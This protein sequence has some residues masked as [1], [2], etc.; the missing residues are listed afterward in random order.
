L[1]YFEA[2]QALSWAGV[3][4]DRMNCFNCVDQE[5]IYKVS[6]LVEDVVAWL[7]NFQ[8]DVIITHPYEGGHP[9]HDAAALIASLALDRLAEES[10][11]VPLLI[12][13]SS[14]HAMN[15]QLRT[16]EFLDTSETQLSIKLTAER[17]RRK[18]RM[19]SCYASQAAVLQSF[20]TDRE[21]FRPAPAYDFHVAPHAGKLWFECLGWEMTGQKWRTLAHAALN[22]MNQHVCR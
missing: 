17:R 9:D 14:Y 13:M 6:S 21:V 7:R 20:G 11:G 16:G 15:Q 19:L 5:A 22:E 2:Q 8:P 18:Q 12:E 3:P 4:R 10:D 1:R